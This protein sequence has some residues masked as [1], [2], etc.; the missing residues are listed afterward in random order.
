[1]RLIGISFFGSS[2]HFSG[3]TGKS[4]A[5]GRPRPPCRPCPLPHWD[6][7]WEFRKGTSQSIGWEIWGD[8]AARACRPWATRRRGRIRTSPRTYR[9]PRVSVPGARLK[10]PSGSP[11]RH[12]GRGPDRV[13]LVAPVVMMDTTARRI[14]LRS[15]R[16]AA[17]RRTE[18]KMGRPGPS[19]QTRL[20]ARV[21]RIDRHIWTARPG[22][23]RN[24]SGVLK[25]F[26]YMLAVLLQ[27][28]LDLPIS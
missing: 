25:K 4:R 19:V 12:P 14:F 23:V 21:V 11:H 10:R 8:R 6:A 16:P 3:E 13:L 27:F 20:G 18:N 7:C 28:R 26:I 15:D 2:D 24:G 9:C 17:G 1:M 5:A 22:R